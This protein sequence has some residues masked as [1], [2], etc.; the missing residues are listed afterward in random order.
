MSNVAVGLTAC[1][2]QSVL[3]FVA[4]RLEVVAYTVYYMLMLY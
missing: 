2:G 1:Y 3:V 4:E